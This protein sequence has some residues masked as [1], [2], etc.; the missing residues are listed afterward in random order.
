M[1]F[2][3]NKEIF[4]KAGYPLHPAFLNIGLGYSTLPQLPLDCGICGRF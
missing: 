4:K 2:D 1:I 3:V